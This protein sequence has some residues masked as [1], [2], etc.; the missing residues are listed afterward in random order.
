MSLISPA[1][2]GGFLT[3]SATWEALSLVA[4]FI[5][6]ILRSLLKAQTQHASGPPPL[7]TVPQLLNM[8]LPPTGLGSSWAALCFTQIL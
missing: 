4:N 7:L 6:I 8:L 2:A 3:T 1:L 5:L